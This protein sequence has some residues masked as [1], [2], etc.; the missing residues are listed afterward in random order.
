MTS[1][2]TGADNNLS[3]LERVAEALRSRGEDARLEHTG[4]GIYCI[5]LPIRGG[6]WMYWGTSD[7]EWGCD[8]YKGEEY[9]RSETLEGVFVTAAAADIDRAAGA[10][11]SFTSELRS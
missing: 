11:T 10:I 2:R 6:E 7:E 1:K 4:G 9:D 8:I 3:I 5:R